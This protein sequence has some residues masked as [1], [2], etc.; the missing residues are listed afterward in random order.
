MTWNKSWYE[1]T[2]LKYK[3]HKTPFK[4]LCDFNSWQYWSLSAS[5]RSRLFTKGLGSKGKMCFKNRSKVQ[6]TH[7][8]W[9]YYSWRNFVGCCFRAESPCDLCLQK[10]LHLHQ[11]PG[12][13]KQL[14]STGFGGLEGIPVARQ[15]CSFVSC[16]QNKTIRFLEKKR[17]PQMP[18]IFLEPFVTRA[19]CW[20]GA[21]Y[22]IFA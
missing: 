12:G 18:G 17:I 4:S 7:Q 16:I 1:L 13:A 2:E 22:W 21:E 5:V 3:I 10:S 8:L 20:S 14:G 9:W 6:V 15:H 19:F 11:H